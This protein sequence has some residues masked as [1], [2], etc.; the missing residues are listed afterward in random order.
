[1]ETEKTIIKVLARE[2]IGS[3][4]IYISDSKKPKLISQEK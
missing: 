2:G 3:A 1:M 4:V